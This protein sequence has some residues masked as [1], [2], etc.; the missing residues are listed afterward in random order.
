MSTIGSLGYAAAVQWTSELGFRLYYIFGALAVA[1][2]MGMGS[3]YLAMPR[4]VADRLMWVVS[5]LLVIGTVLLFG[6][7][8]DSAALAALAG[9]SGQG[10][11]LPGP[12]LITMILLNFFGTAAVA[13]IAVFS[14]WRAARSRSDVG[15]MWG[16]LV[17]GLGFLTLAMA[18]SMAR[19]FPAWDGGFWVAM[20]VGWLVAYIGFRIVT[21]AAEAR[22]SR[23]ETT[24]Q[25]TS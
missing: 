1:P 18:G 21:K 20:A 10:V 7:R 17:I 9:G 16:N 15:F 22:R 8:I 5:A 12:W 24:V 14:A 25:A 6:A 11:F 2:V 23:S 4:K 19:W 3:V 13:G